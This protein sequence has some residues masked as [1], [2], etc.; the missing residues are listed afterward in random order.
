MEAIGWC[1]H[2]DE[3]DTCQCDVL[4]TCKVKYSD[5]EEIH[6]SPKNKCECGSLINVGVAHSCPNFYYAKIPLTRVLVIN[7]NTQSG[8]F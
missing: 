1:K 6:Y 3:C 4:G 2:L 8:V 7:R 5:T